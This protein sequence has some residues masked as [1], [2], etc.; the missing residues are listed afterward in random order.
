MLDCNH[1][2][3]IECFSANLRLFCKGNQPIDMEGGATGERRR[4]C[5]RC[6]MYLRME[7]LRKV[8]LPLTED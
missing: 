6:R 1:L 7:P 2:S 4:S 3:E 5:E 8:V